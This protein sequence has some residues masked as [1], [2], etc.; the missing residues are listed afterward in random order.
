MPA[1]VADQYL[2]M[3]KELAASRFG[4]FT[5]E[6]IPSPMAQ[7]ESYGRDRLGIAAVA[8]ENPK[9]TLRAP[10]TSE[11]FQ[12]ALYAIYRHIFGNTYVME[13]ERPTTA[14]SQLKDGRITVRG[15]IRL[16]AKSEVYKSRFFQKTSQNRFIELSHKLLLG[17]AP[18]DQAEISYH[19][20]LWNTQGYDAEIDSYV[21]SE[22][23]LDFFGEDTVPFLRDFKYQTGQQGV[24]YSRLLNLYDGYAGSDTDRAQ[25]GQKARLNGTIAQAEPGSIERPSALQDTW[26][27]A[28][29][30]YRNA[31]PPMVKALA[32]EPFLDMARE[33]T[34][35]PPTR[36]VDL[37]F[38]NMA[39]DLTSVSRAE[40]LAKSYT[41]PSRYQQTET[42]GQERIGAVGAIET[43]RIN[44]RAPFT[45]EEFQG[46]LY[47]IY[48]HIFGNTYVMESERPTTAESQ[49]KD[50][51]ITV[52]GFIRLLAKSEVYKSRFFQKT[53]Q[54]RFIE[55]S[56]K[57]LL[58]RA[59]YDQ[60]E[61]SYHLDLWNTQ[62]YD[63]EI[64]SY[65]DSE[66]YL[67]FFGEDTVPYFRGF[68]YQ[69]GQS[70]EGF[71][72]LVRLY[73]GWAG[74]DTDRNVGGQVARLTANLT[75]GGSGL[76]PFIVMANSRR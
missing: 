56:H 68:K 15:F 14:E 18:Y 20:D 27:F 40:W 75:R 31:K 54:N 16:L 12:G 76:E 24:G 37:L 44:L 49:L 32:L 9:V 13:S 51:R 5:K 42:F 19:L 65:V 6:N 26:K 60:A 58:G 61:I 22:E 47:A 29:P 38:L 63:A 55:L 11:E 21:D 46:A 28:N 30:N 2:A 69:T 59:P 10:F 33:L 74:S 53:S 57:L 71:N 50:G 8:T 36:Q 39:K 62:G 34:P 43:P 70:A 72:R 4:G 41:Q 48:R 3:A 64:D 73:D 45:S 67:D 17:R 52:R 23:Y 7:P 1:V 25:S 66:E 35:K